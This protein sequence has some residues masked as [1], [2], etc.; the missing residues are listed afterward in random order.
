MNLQVLGSYKKLLCIS[1]SDDFALH[2]ELSEE[3]CGHL[4][5]Q[6][7]RCEE[8]LVQPFPWNQRVQMNLQVLGS[9]GLEFFLQPL[10]LFLLV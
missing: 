10:I 9:E 1:H 6:Q 2:E 8:V 3:E 4:I 5:G 7:F